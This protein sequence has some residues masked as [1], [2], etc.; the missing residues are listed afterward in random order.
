LC[1][2]ASGLILVVG[3]A[4][5]ARRGDPRRDGNMRRAAFV[6]AFWME[7]AMF[8]RCLFSALASL[9]LLAPPAGAADKAWED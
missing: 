9:P 8:R 6:Y 1:N 4:G 5:H 7:D 3:Y 2:R